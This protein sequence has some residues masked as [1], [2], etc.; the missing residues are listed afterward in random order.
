MKPVAIVCVSVALSVVLA[1]SGPIWARGFGGGGGG[2]HVG[3]V[4][5]GWGGGGHVGGF[6]HVPAPTYY[7]A[8]YFA[9]SPREAYHAPAAPAY[10]PGPV[11]NYESHVESFR[12]SYAARENVGRENLGR[13][14]FG[15]R[16]DVIRG[17][18]NLRVAPLGGGAHPNVNHVVNNHWDR[19]NGHGWDNAWYH[20][21]WHGHWDHYWHGGWGN[22]W[23]NPW[24]S[25]A[26]WGVTGWGLGAAVYDWGYL[27]YYNPYYVQS[28]TFGPSVIN[29]EQPI[30]TVDYADDA[31]DGSGNG[32]AVS[33]EATQHADAARE[34]FY[35]EN[36]R[37]ALTEIQK[38]IGRMPGDPAF[39]EFRAL[40]LFALHEYRAA[41]AAVHS[42]LA[43]GPGWDWTTMIG[44]YPSEDVYTKQLRALENFRRDHPNDA[45]ARFLLAYQYMT[46]GYT[47]AAATELRAVMKLQPRDQVA[48]Q[49]LS[50]ITT[51][52]PQGQS[53]SPP[54]NAEEPNPTETA[55]PPKGPPVDLASLTGTWTARREDGSS[56]QLTLTPDA[57]F[58]WRYGQGDRSHEFTGTATASNNL[59]ILQQA[60]GESM[61]GR[62][63]PGD[64]RG[65]HFYLV[66]GPPDDPGLTFTP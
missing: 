65:F 37:L 3:G 18:G 8:G 46:M 34:A 21:H 1:K 54:P 20:G 4:G 64:G 14:N 60:N 6:G 2:G 31:S 12:P 56:I 48:N 50:M 53:G 5:G 58:T 24:Y 44:L 51:A 15:R 26:F 35:N 7:G 59:L 16:T 45:A 9:P 27:P 61:V 39:H 11:R 42:L 10:R 36:Y 22:W 33:P 40:C 55:P 17:T 32:P 57:H 66:G 62:V 43:V 38:A 30:Q 47:Q 63:V 28:Y 19:W 49:L 29:Y 13:E 52:P 25:G 23:L 41:A